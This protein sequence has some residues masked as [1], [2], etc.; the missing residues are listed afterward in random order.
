V[1]NKT[2][3]LSEARALLPELK[4]DL[5][6]LQSLMTEYN[7]RHI[8]LEW[9]KSLFNLSPDGA[10]NE[11]DAFFEEESRIDFKRL[12]IN[13]LI[14][15]FT[16]KGVLLKSVDPG[17]IDFPAVMDGEAVLICWKEGEE[18]ITHYHGWNDG[19]I[20]RKPLPDI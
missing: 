1:E 14:E 19:F 6:T 9:K 4:E 16:R 15:N 10:G 18:R 3:S 7:Q 2:F 13:L 5:R 20:G 8:E 12:E 11:E 17:L